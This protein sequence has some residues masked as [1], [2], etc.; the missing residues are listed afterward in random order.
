[1]SLDYLVP[2]HGD[3]RRFHLSYTE[4]RDSYLHF[5]ALSDDDFITSL[6]RALHLACVIS[7]LKELPPDATLGDYG[8]VH[9]LVHLMTDAE[10]KDELPDIREQYNRMLELA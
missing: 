9:R 5:V 10:D 7:W 6:P 2:H 8:I 4:L 1:M 3:D